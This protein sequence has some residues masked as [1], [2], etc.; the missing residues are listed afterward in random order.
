VI[1]DPLSLRFGGVTLHALPS[2]TLRIL[3]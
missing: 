1:D 3:K 2:L